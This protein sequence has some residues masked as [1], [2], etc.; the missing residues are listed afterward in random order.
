VVLLRIL[1]LI[2]LIKL[3]DG[4][5]GHEN[6]ISNAKNKQ[7]SPIIGGLVLLRPHKVSSAPL[8]RRSGFDARPVRIGFVVEKVA[9]THVSLSTHR[10]SQM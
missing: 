4:F 3:S 9:V 6:I 8:T 2:F 10:F 7:E 5:R 1:T